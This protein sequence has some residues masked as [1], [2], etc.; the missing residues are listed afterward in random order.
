MNDT[1]GL[2]YDDEAAVRFVRT[3]TGLDE[4]T[5]R[6]VLR[7]RTRYGLG[8]GT[9]PPEV[10]DDETPEQ[11][12]AAQPDLFPASH[13]TEHLVD[14]TLERE[15]IMRDSDIAEPLIRAVLNADHE[16]MRGRGLVD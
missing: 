13:L 1:S 2:I 7:S 14:T 11:V 4:D 3:A 10:A 5:I 12:R 6:A 9:L 16:Y 8:L 15:Y